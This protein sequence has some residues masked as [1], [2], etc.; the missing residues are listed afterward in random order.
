MNEWMNEWM[1]SYKCMSNILASRGQL[2]SAQTSD[3]FT[4]VITRV[5]SSERRK[6]VV[7]AFRA[8]LPW[9]NPGTIAATMQTRL[10]S[11][12]SQ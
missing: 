8:G 11:G 5:L 12:D 9:T 3:L 10:D 7:R 1:K 6:Q 2:S 4:H